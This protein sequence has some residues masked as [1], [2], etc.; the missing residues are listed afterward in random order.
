M[1]AAPIPAA[2]PACRT[3]PRRGKAK[4]G[5][6]DRDPPGLVRA[7]SFR[8]WPGWRVV[9]PPPTSQHLFGPPGR[10]SQPSW[11]F[12]PSR[13]GQVRRRPEPARQQRQRR[14]V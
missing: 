6:L 14:N 9:R 5:R 12:E 11:M 10:I 4:S 13:R 1:G 2:P 8:T 3:K 7:A